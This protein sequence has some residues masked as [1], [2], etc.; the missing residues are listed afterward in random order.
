[1]G[2]YNEHTKCL[3]SGEQLIEMSG[4]NWWMIKPAWNCESC[5]NLLGMYVS[6]Y[7]TSLHSGMVIF[8]HFLAFGRD[9]LRPIESTNTTQQQRVMNATCAAFDNNMVVGYCSVFVVD[10]CSVKTFCSFTPL[11]ASW[12]NKK[13]CV[14]H[15]RNLSYVWTWKRVK[16]LPSLLACCSF[17]EYTVYKC[18]VSSCV[19]SINFFYC[20]VALCDL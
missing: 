8:S 17:L 12:S 16:D 7:P 9:R 4:Q 13:M 15:Q 5:P 18:S 6:L 2:A 11:V 19:F 14:I 20:R 1:M 10:E 3:R